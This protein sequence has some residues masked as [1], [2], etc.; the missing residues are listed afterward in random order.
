VWARWDDRRDRRLDEQRDGDIPRRIIGQIAD[1]RLEHRLECFVGAME[2]AGEGP[3]LGDPRIQQR[4]VHRFGR[5]LELGQDGCHLVP[6]DGDAR[7]VRAHLSLLQ[8]VAG[9]GQPG[10]GRHLALGDVEVA[11]DERADDAPP[12]HLPQDSVRWTGTG[13]A[14]ISWSDCRMSSGCRARHHTPDV[15]G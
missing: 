2:V 1:P 10:P 12:G 11:P 9:Q 8:R 5:G 15:R 4:E 3:G 6:L 7:K 13:R 14:D